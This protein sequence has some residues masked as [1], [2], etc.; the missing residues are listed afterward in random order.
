MGFIRG[1][2][3]ITI[4]RRSEASTDTHG[5]PE[6]TNTSITVKDA[7]ISVESSSETIDPERDAIDASLTLYLPMGTQILPGDKF[8]IRGTTWIKDSSAQEWISP[9]PMETGVIVKVRKRIG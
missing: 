5:N 1:G 9:F 3:T 7:L 2:E 6:Y 8:V 4:K